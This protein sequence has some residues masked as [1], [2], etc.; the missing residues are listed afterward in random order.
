MLA[1]IGGIFSSPTLTNWTPRQANLDKMEPESK[2]KSDPKESQVALP[3][4]RSVKKHM[5]KEDTKP[6]EKKTIK[7]VINTSPTRLNGKQPPKDSTPTAT[8]G[9]HAE[10][11]D[12]KTE[13]K[14]PMWAWSPGRVRTFYGLGEVI[15]VASPS[16]SEPSH[17]SSR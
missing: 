9:C 3:K 8:R 14:S 5:L 11:K 15:H 2:K 17:T 16:V 13:N 12:Q 1:F 6:P 10:N 4:T 7:D